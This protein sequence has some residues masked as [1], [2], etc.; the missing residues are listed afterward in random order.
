MERGQ[1]EERLG[2]L[3]FL[4]RRPFAGA[5]VNLRRNFLLSLLD[6]FHSELWRLGGLRLSSLEAVPRPP[7]RRRRPRQRLA[8]GSLES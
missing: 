2:G 7:R 8:P 5:G 6:L 1:S 4:R 3:P